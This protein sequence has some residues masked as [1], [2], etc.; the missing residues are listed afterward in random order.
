MLPQRCSLAHLSVADEKHF[1]TAHLAIKLIAPVQFALMIWLSVQIGHEIAGAS[2]AGSYFASIASLFGIV[3]VDALASAA[4][5][6]AGSCR[7]APGVS[8]AS[9]ISAKYSGLLGEVK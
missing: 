2:F 5:L 8:L 9:L 3:V 4:F 6:L 1:D 7:A